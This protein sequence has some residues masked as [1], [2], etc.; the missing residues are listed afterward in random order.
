MLSS[1][2]LIDCIFVGLPGHLM[3][4][5]RSHDGQTVEK[6]DQ[7]NLLV[8]VPKMVVGIDSPLVGPV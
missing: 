3:L 4:E 6:V 5:F 7:V 1:N 2:V 8:P